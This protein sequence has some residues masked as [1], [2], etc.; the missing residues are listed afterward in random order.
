MNIKYGDLRDAK[1]V[2]FHL[3]TNNAKDYFTERTDMSKDYNYPLYFEHMVNDFVE[4]FKYFK[5]RFKVH[6]VKF[7][8]EI[9][10][11][12]FTI[13]AVNDEFNFLNTSITYA[14]L[15]NN[16]CKNNELSYENIMELLTNNRFDEHELLRQDKI[17]EC[18]DHYTHVKYFEKCLI[19]KIIYF[20]FFLKE[21]GYQDMYTDILDKENKKEFDEILENLEDMYVNKGE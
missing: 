15:T 2:E 20:I 21:S 18:S 9:R 17:G 10:K 7:K 19:F 13:K 5:V 16:Y 3:F 11:L 8:P 12:T 14:F 1:L 6:I 4:Y